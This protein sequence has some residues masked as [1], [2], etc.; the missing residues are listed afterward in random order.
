MD[1][2]NVGGT[3]LSQHE[4]PIITN[5]VDDISE[6]GDNYDFDLDDEDQFNR[7]SQYISSGNQSRHNIDCEL[8]E[9]MS[10]MSKEATLNA[11]KR[12]HIDNDY[13][14]VVV[15]SKSDRYVA[16]CIH[17]DYIASPYMVD[18][19][20]DNSYYTLDRVFWSFKPC[21]NGFNFCKLI[22]QVD[23]T[24]LT[25]RYHGTL[26]TAT[27]QDGNR[28]IF[29]LAFA[30][31]E[32]ETRET[33]IWFFQLLQQYVTPQPNLCMIND[34]GIG[35][36]SALQ[37]EEVGWEGDGLVSVYCIR[38]ITSNFNKKFK[39]AEL[40]RQLINMVQAKLSVM[41]SEFKQAFSW[42]DRIPL[43]KWT[44][45]YDGE[46]SFVLK[47]ARSLSISALVKTTFEKT[48]TWFVERVFKIDTMLRASH[49]YSE[50]ITTLLR[51]NQQ[52]S[53]MCFVE[54]F[55][56]ENSEFDVQELA[57]LQHGRRPQ[58]YTVR[59]NDW[60]CDYGHFQ[61]L[62]L[63]CRHVI[64]VC[65]SCHLQMTTF[66]DPIYNLHTIR[67]AY[68]VEFHPVR[69]EDYWSTYTGPNFILEPHMR[70]KNSRRPITTRLHNEIDQSIQNK[71]KKC[72]YCRNEGHNRGNCPFRQ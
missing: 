12:Y 51:K 6:D 27:A 58:S 22:V 34:R 60:W 35:I 25:G 49:Y 63:P 14:F 48:K 18:G 46:K 38:H 54:R 17:H 5:I 57:T 67:K 3:S 72:S 53:S 9:H 15:E 23:G 8:N 45:A 21:I 1:T 24:F 55:N 10:F 19:V 47:G 68:Q 61:A 28:N 43:E 13:K 71:T 4:E 30:I 56:A 32:G 40:K 42:I 59:L 31:V 29:P 11:I 36:I 44:Q 7:F 20:Q 39:N 50:D 69:N 64:V 16:R 65:S 33:L 41:R 70:R 66:I 52:D 62:R 26:L 37:S 2:W